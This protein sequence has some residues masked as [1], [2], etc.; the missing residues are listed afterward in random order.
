MA[1]PFQFESGRGTPRRKASPH[2]QSDSDTERSIQHLRTHRSGFHEAYLYPS[3]RAEN[4]PPRK[5]ISR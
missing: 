1:L 4:L 2:L 3:K 5:K